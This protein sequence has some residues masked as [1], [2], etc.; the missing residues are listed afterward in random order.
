[1]AEADRYSARKP[2][3][4]TPTSWPGSPSSTPCYPPAPRA[5]QT[6]IPTQ[7]RRRDPPRG[8]RV[9]ALRAGRDTNSRR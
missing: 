8:G 4:T 1:V 2:P 7:A 5:G 3:A 6:S 9:Q